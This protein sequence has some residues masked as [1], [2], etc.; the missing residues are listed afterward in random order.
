MER[1]TVRSLPPA[2]MPMPTV[3]M[4]ASR[5][6]MQTLFVTQPSGRTWKKPE[7]M[8]STKMPTRVRQAFAD[9]P[10]EAS[11]PALPLPAPLSAAPF[12]E[13]LL[14]LPFGEGRKG[15]IRQ[16]QSTEPAMV[17]TASIRAWTPIMGRWA[18]SSALP[19]VT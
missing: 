7:R 18:M 6:T 2:L 10:P 12:P 1:R 19:P 5:N 9:D 16:T 4:S 11:S 8:P 15:Q 17:A 14:P 3:S 13:H